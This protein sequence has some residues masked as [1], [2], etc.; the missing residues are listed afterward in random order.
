[1]QIH[2]IVLLLLLV[3]LGTAPVVFAEEF[4]IKAGDTIQK[5]LEYR[6]GKRVTLR[7]QGGEEISGKVRTVTGE[8][9]QLGELSGREYFDAVVDV[10]RISS[11]IV[12]V[13]E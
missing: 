1:M 6:K 11:V 9:V 10:S 8:L 4:S 7:L 12:R 5:V 3:C 13:K 2:R